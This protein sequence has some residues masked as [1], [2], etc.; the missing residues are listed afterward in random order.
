M[1]KGSS[2]SDGLDWYLYSIA[3]LHSFWR[4]E[5]EGITPEIDRVSAGPIA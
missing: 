3:Y 5:I 2:D 1:R 4:M